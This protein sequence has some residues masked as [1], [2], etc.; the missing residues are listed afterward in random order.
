[1]CGGNAGPVLDALD[2]VL[3]QLEDIRDGLES[4]DPIAAVR[5]WATPAHAA[6]SVWPHGW[7]APRQIPATPNHLLALGREGGWVTAVSS[8]GRTVTAARPV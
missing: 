5:R 6:R 3:S 2:E 7:G 4:D 1:M 8:D